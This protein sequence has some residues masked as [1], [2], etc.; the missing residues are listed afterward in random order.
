MA[1]SFEQP[2]FLFTVA[3]FILMIGP[4]VFVHEMGHY[5][6][7][8]LFG[9]KVESFS[10]GF[11]QQV[12][13]WTDRRGTVWRLS[14][15]PLGGYVKFAGDANAAGAGSDGLDDIPDAERHHYFAFKPLWQRALIVLAGPVINFLFA[16]LI[17]AGFF[18]TMGQPVMPPV[19]D[20]VLENS[21]AQEAGLRPG[22]EIVEVDGLRVEQFEDLSQQVVINPGKPMRI[23]LLRNGEPLTTIVTPKIIETTDR[24]GNRGRVGQLGVVS[25]GGFERHEVG[26]FRS[27]VL[28]TEQTGKAVRQMIAVLKQLILGERSIKELGGPLKIGQLSGQVGSEG[29]PSFI[30]FMAFISINLGFINLLP[31]PMLDGGHL[32]LY[33]AEAVRGGKP[34]PE[35]AQQWAFMGGFALVASFML[36]V[37]FNDL[38]SFGLWGHV[39]GLFG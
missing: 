26:F 32:A 5:L 28:G 36:V 18:F 25:S 29:A 10:I 14:L 30:W 21:A 17:F 39:R 22:D 24:F 19:V 38:A 33:A 15:L 8:R 37:T 11:G 34:V 4:L 27:L 35:K 7:G 12:A 31:I 3:M 20:Q 9:T 1:T 2:G 13:G 6:V 23:S 16:I